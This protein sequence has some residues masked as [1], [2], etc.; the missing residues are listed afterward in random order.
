MHPQ[1]G[2]VVARLDEARLRLQRLA[3]RL[4]ASQATERRDSTRWSVA[5]NVAHLNL[6][7]RAFLPLLENGLLEAGR[8]GGQVTTYRRDPAG[9]A[10]S[11]VVGPQMRIAGKRLGSV[12]T[13]PPFVPQAD[14]PFIFI[15]A[16]FNALQDTLTELVRSSEGLPIDQV[17]LGSPFNER[18]R[19]SVYSAFVIIPRHQLRHITHAEDQWKS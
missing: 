19:Y 5:E 17:R 15:L 4:S 6:T 8:I 2:D 7:T 11:L 1:L 18:V 9:W 12:G 13:P 10:L 16:E 3:S 14:K